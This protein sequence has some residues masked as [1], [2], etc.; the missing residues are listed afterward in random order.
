MTIDDERGSRTRVAGELRRN[1]RSDFEAAGLEVR[2]DGSDELPRV[3]ASCNARAHARFDHAGHDAAPTRMHQRANVMRRIDE[4][5]RRAVGR[6]DD[7]NI[8]NRIGDDAVEIGRASCRE[9]V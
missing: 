4:P 2:S 1:F 7:R 5:H 6:Q 3:G 8:L 9:R